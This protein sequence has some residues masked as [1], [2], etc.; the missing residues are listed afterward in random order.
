MAAPSEDIRSW[1]AAPPLD[2]CVHL[3][4]MIEMLKFLPAVLALVSTSF[5]ISAIAAEE[6]YA[7]CAAS[8]TCFSRYQMPYTIACETYGASCQ[9]WTNPYQSV[10]CTGFDFYGRW[11]S[12]YFVCQ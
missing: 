1:C 10:Q 9:W 12:L 3:R 2:R 11:V 7:V 4:Q 6:Q 8:T 5:T